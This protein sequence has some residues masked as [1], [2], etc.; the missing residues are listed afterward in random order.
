MC[1]LQC[2]A[3]YNN[4][5]VYM[6]GVDRLV[7]SNN[8]KAYIWVLIRCSY[9]SLT[10]QSHIIYDSKTIG[11]ITIAYVIIMIGTGVIML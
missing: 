8:S 9:H 7:L 5:N 1:A 10:N 3:N 4:S 11:S 6:R 2:L